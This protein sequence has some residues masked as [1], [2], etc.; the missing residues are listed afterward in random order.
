[1]VEKVEIFKKKLQENAEAR[2]MFVLEERAL[3]LTIDTIGGAVMYVYVRFHQ[4]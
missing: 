4:H 2:T 3:N 1:M